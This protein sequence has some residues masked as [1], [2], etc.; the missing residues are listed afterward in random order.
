MRHLVDRQ[1]LAVVGEVRPAAPQRDRAA[2]LRRRHR[3]Q[4]DRQQVHRDPADGGAAH[5]VDQHR[6]AAAGR[7]R[8]AVGVTA[9]DDADAQGLIGDEAAAIAHAVARLQLLQADQLGAQRHRRL[10]APVADVVLGKVGRAAVDQ[11][12]GAHPVRGQRRSTGRGRVR[13][14]VAQHRRAVA[15]TALTRQVVRRG[16]EGRH[17]VG[18]AAGAVGIGEMRHQRDLVD[19]RQRVQPHPGTAKGS[20]R[21]AQPVHAAVHLQ[22]HPVRLVGLVHRQPVDLLLAVHRMPQVQPRAQL[23]VARLERPFQQQDGAAPVEC[24]QPLGLGQVEQRKTIGGAQRCE[25]LLEPM[26]VGVGFDDRPDPRVGRLGAGAGQV[27]GQ[28]IGVDQRF[29]RTGHRPILPAAAAAAERR[30]CWPRV[31]AITAPHCI[32]PSGRRCCS[33]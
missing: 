16:V 20:R 7:A 1:H 30:R 32:R 29:D 23:E 27:V 25:R 33:R 13:A 28:G 17:L 4:V 14:H 9:G 18:D 8:V 19:L 5:A 24:A 12:A 31:R 6:R 2:D 21:E 3:A 11:D 22:K 10:Q 15:Q 26:A